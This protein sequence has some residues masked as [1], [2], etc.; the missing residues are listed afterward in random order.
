MTTFAT[1]IVAL[2]GGLSLTVALVAAVFPRELVVLPVG[3]IARSVTR[4]TSATIVGVALLALL[5]WIFLAP[6]ILLRAG[7][8]ANA[9]LVLPW[10]A[11]IPILTLGLFLAQGIGRVAAVALLVIVSGGFGAGVASVFEQADGLPQTI[12]PTIAFV[13]VLSAVVAFI[14]WANTEPSTSSAAHEKVSPC[15]LLSESSR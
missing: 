7:G 6:G 8:R 4:R 12:T 10:I 14:W 1:L 9:I 13:I 5:T 3:R 15:P 11:T 2:S